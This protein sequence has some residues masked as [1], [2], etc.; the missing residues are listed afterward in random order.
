MPL[1]LGL[2]NYVAI[3]PTVTNTGVRVATRFGCWFPAGA[4]FMLYCVQAAVW[5]SNDSI[6]LRINE[7]KLAQSF[8][9]HFL[10]IQAVQTVAIN[11]RSPECCQLNVSYPSGIQG[12]L[13][14]GIRQLYLMIKFSMKKQ[15]SSVHFSQTTVRCWYDIMQVFQIIF[16]RMRSSFSLFYKV[17]C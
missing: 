12:S 15:L 9:E 2:G 11:I 3:Y 17:D 1:E 10:E 13:L 7:V 6:G 14:N 8:T 16:G 4:L 5:T